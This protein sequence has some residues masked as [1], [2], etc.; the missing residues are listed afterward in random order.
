MSGR[1]SYEERRDL[2]FAKQA[3]RKRR[4]ELRKKGCYV[5]FALIA[6]ILIFKMATLSGKAQD[7]KEIKYKYYTEIKVKYGD[8]L[9]SIAG[10]YVDEEFNTRTSLV[11]E[12][13][14]INHISNEDE[15]LV[16]QMLIIPYYSSEY[17]KD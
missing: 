13:K 5:L 6:F 4:A 12:I 16:G 14:S 15:I 7:P 17:V 8:T 11:K 1:K 3:A 10:K 2:I 9:W